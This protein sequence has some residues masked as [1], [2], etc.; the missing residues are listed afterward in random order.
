MPKTIEAIYEDGV[1]KPLD[2]VPLPEHTRIRLTLSPTKDWAEKFRRL[3]NKVHQRT[4]NIPH[5][6]FQLGCHRNI[7][8]KMLI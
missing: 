6:H 8:A 3:L 4:R 5:F 2:Q 7:T 1:F